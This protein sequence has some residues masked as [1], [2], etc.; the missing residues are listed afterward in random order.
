M[1]EK[2]YLFKRNREFNDIN[3][4]IPGLYL[5]SYDVGAKNEE[6][7]KNLGITHILSIMSG[8]NEYEYKTFKGLHHIILELEDNH[9]PYF[10][11]ILKNSYSTINS[12][13]YSDSDPDPDLDPNQ[14]II[15]KKYYEDDKL[16]TKLPKKNKNKL[17]I[18]CKAGISRSVT[19]VIYFLMIK[20]NY[21]Y[22][23]AY[24]LIR[25]KRPFINPN[26]WFKNKL[27][28]IFITSRGLDKEIFIQKKIIYENFCKLLRDKILKQQIFTNEDIIK[29]QKTFDYVFDS[30]SRFSIEIIKEIQEWNYIFNE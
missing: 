13:L 22:F 6:A 4:I 15:K 29:V 5:S 23:T 21:S 14:S 2:D 9:N 26:D 16:L 30:N 25:K 18:H 12:I 3:R 1:N 11:N 10:E 20:F 19:I 28:K 27:F 8:L 7:C 17:L 24:E